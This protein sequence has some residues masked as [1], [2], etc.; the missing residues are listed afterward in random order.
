MEIKIESIVPSTEEND[1]RY[2]T[3]GNELAYVV[4]TNLASYCIE[5]IRLY[6]DLT[7]DKPHTVWKLELNYIWDGIGMDLTCIE[8]FKDYIPDT[9]ILDWFKEGDFIHNGEYK[10]ESDDQDTFHTWAISEDFA[11]HLLNE[12]L[13]EGNFPDILAGQDNF[14]HFLEPTEECDGCGKEVE[15]DETTEV[16][17]LVYCEKCMDR[18]AHEIV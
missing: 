12:Y 3:E 10:E 14:E 2:D 13:K 15:T 11:Q 4:Y 1:P 9:Q 18:P 5:G 8:Q 6:T 17:G 16:K 7:E